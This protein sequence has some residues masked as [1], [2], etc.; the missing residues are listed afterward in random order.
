MTKQ[1]FFESL[2]NG[3]SGLPEEELHERLEFYS[4]MIDDR[5]E[6][7]LSEEEAV[8]ELGSPDEV[9][10]KI[11]SE[12]PLSKIVK[13]KIK[14]TKKP[15]TWAILLIVLGFPVWLPLLAAGFAVT[16]AIYAVI[17]SLIISAWSVVAALGGSS[18]GVLLAGASMI[19][20]G[21]I[22][23]SLALTG[24]SLVLAGLMLFAIYGCKKATVGCI[25]LTKKILILIKKCFIGKESAI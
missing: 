22:P 4:E 17:W 6:D 15:E 12:I 23:T 8:K 13:K 21:K 14:S 5:I 20:V 11:L 16:L 18:I 2:K 24:A 25:S 10:A 1:E 9:I 3:L 19:F 7:G